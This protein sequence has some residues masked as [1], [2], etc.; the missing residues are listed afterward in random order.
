MRSTKKYN[1]NNNNMAYG[2][3]EYLAQGCVVMWCV[4]WGCGSVGKHL[5][6]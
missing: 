1:E 3:W 6:G 2:D 4:W 5:I